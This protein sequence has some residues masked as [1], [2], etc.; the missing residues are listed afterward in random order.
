[1]TETGTLDSGKDHKLVFAILDFGE[2]QRA[3]GLG[4]RLHNEHTRHDRQIGEVTGEEWFIDGHIFDGHNARFAREINYSV[5]QQKRETVRQDAQDVINVQR[6]L[7]CG[8]W[9]LGDRMSS[10]GHSAV[11]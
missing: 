3:P 1:M 11:R 8:G 4:N 6:G 9:G 2:Q 10:V 5:N 7:A